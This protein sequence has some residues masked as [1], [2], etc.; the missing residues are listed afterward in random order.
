MM[1]LITGWGERTFWTRFVRLATVRAC[2]W[3]AVRNTFNTEPSDNRECF[4]RPLQNVLQILPILPNDR[5]FFVGVDGLAF[6]ESFIRS[7]EHVRSI[8]GDFMIFDRVST[9]LGNYCG[10]YRCW[11]NVFFARWAIPNET[12]IVQVHIGD[13]RKM[14]L[15]MIVFLTVR[16]F[17]QFIVNAREWSSRNGYECGWKFHWW[18]KIE[19]MKPYWLAFD[20]STASI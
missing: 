13:G 10:A 6:E 19:Q 14:A 3:F 15:L 18:L 11:R 12:R 8:N 1:T 9:I 4:K 5:T 20:A 2:R 16:T 7:C 17:Y